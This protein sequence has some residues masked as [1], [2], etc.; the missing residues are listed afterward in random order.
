MIWKRNEGIHLE[1][2]F[3][4]YITPGFSEQGDV[5]GKGQELAPVAGE[6]V[7]IAGCFGSSIWHFYCLALGV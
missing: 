2:M 6:E 1:G 3:G 7:G 5:F 4:H